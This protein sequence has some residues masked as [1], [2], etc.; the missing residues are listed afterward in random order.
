ME[1][2]ESKQGRIHGSP[3]RGRLGRGSNELGGG[4]NKVGRGSNELGRRNNEFGRTIKG[5]C[6]LKV[7]A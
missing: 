7:K 6:T 4:S 5:I 2:H 3:R 1:D